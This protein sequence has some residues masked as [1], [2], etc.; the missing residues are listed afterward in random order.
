MTPIKNLIT[1]FLLISF[2]FASAQDITLDQTLKYMNNKFGGK[3]IVQI[4]NGAI[5]AEY[6]N[7]DE[8]VRQDKVDPNDLDLTKVKYDPAEKQLHINCTEEREGCV[9]RNLLI[10][11]ARNGYKRLSFPYEGNQKSIDGLTKALTHLVKLMTDKKYK[12][13]TPFE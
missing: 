9:D 6:F 11:G 1:F 2:K 13:S 8:K 12:S 10:T 4:K 7:K 3:I 5:L